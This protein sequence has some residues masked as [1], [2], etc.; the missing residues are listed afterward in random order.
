MSRSVSVSKNP[1]LL[2]SESVKQILSV[3]VIQILLGTVQPVFS[4]RN[5]G[6]SSSVVRLL[7]VKPSRYGS[8]CLDLDADQYTNCVYPILI[9]PQWS[10][11]SSVMQSLICDPDLNELKF[12]M[13]ETLSASFLAAGYGSSV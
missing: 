12:L 7:S 11:D 3:P 10:M 1:Y 4:N 2:D 13:G 6:K 9:D 5:R 8:V